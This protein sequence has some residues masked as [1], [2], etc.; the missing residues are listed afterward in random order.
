MLGQGYSFT[1]VVAQM[2]QTAEG[3]SSVSPILSLAAQRGVDM[4]IVAQVS[5]V[6]AGT[7]NPRDIAPHLTT[8]DAP[9]ILAE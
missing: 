6:L 3:L 2:N 1:D 7:M 8:D 5:Q 4:P 9:L